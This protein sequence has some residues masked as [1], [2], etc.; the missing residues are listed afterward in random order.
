MSMDKERARSILQCYKAGSLA[1]E[2][3]LFEALELAGTDAELR[4]WLHEN[5][6]LD[7]AIGAKI[8]AAAPA[9]PEDLAREIIRG[10]AARNIPEPSRREKWLRPW[11]MA[12]AITVFLGI[13]LMALKKNT[14]NA[15]DEL[16]GFRSEMA[17]FLQEFPKLDFYSEKQA[18]IRQWLSSKERF[19]NAK[20]PASLEKFPAI[21]CREITWNGKNAVLLCFMADGEVIH[22]F[23][24]PAAEWSPAVQ[25][26]ARFFKAGRHSI[27][28]WKAGNTLHL[29]ITPGG[30]EFLRKTLALTPG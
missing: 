6:R 29:A 15:P 13:S 27:A 22:L 14:A 4:A 10:L 3:E 18:E 5:E 1:E 24:L 25:A 8:R 26:A 16:A 28:S 23:L 30:E 11:A 9:P 12:A 7:R 17:S 19:S 20:I 2:T 21:G